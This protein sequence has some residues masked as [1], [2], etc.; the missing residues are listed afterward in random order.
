MLASA[1]RSDRE[2]ERVIP[3]GNRRPAEACSA[4]PWSA[5]H[6]H[7]LLLRAKASG[8]IQWNFDEI[9]YYASNASVG[10]EALARNRNDCAE[11]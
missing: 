7:S 9:Q 11:Y 4:F 8:R 10:A 6:I 1:I 5:T 3:H 2:K